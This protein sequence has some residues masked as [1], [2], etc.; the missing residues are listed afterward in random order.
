[1]SSIRTSLSLSLFALV[2][3]LAGCGVEAGVPEAE[4]AEQ[5]AT[6]AAPADVAVATADGKGGPRFGGGRHHGGPASLIMAALHEDIGLTA[7]QKTTIEALLPT[8]GDK[9][10]GARPEARGGPDQAHGAALAAAIRSGKVDAA[11]LAPKRDESKA[12]DDSAHVARQAEMAKALGTLHATLTA[13]QRQKLVAAVKSHEGKGGP[14]AQRPGGKGRPDGARPEGRGPKGEGQE[15]GAMHGPLGGML[16]GIELTAEQKELLQT[17]LEAARPAKPTEAEMA[18]HK[19][20]FEAMRTEHEARLATF[21]NDS[22]DA[23]AFLARPAK[24]QGAEAFKGRDH[25]ADEL[26]IVVSVLQPAQRE[27]LA[28]K[29]EAGPPARDG[30]PTRR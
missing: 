29:I 23:N 20:Q 1:M 10:E 13:E 5:A 15:K 22:F 7:E 21:A 25:H 14:D 8:R 6:A 30:K 27:Q 18:A 2:A 26:A 16:A 24:P 17:K 11:A 19:Q 4:S 3:T 28:A 9:P 12:K